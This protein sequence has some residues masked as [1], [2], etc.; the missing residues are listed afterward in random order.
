MG[1]ASGAVTQW[2]NLVSLDRIVFLLF[3]SI[4]LHPLSIPHG[5]LVFFPPCSLF[6][7]LFPQWL[8][9]YKIICQIVCGT[10]AIGTMCM[11]V[12]M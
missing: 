9:C 12:W 10:G 11:S 8:W 3:L 2:S 6:G 4:F 1:Q 5:L 7:R